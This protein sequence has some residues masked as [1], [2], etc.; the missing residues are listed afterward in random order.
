V[1]DHYAG[2]I[3]ERPTL[4]DDLKRIALGEAEK[5]DLIAFLESLSSDGSADRYGP[6]PAPVPVAAAAKPAPPLHGVGEAASARAAEPAAADAGAVVSQKDKSF[7]PGTV[8][9][10]EGGV[11]TITND[12]T[13][14]HNVRVHDPDLE[15]DSGVQ[16]PGE[17]VRLRFPHA[18][19][20][21]AFC[22]I[23]PKMKLT[24][25]VGP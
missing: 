2:G 1:L 13:H 19:T 6:S 20:Y 18:G 22:G 25:R 24:V 12:D 10:Q 11:L 8:A 14:K 16:A 3:V 23:H 17:T 21:Q 15:Y 4:S 7:R 9:L 5:G